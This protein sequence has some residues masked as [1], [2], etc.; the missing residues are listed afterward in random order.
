MSGLAYHAMHTA[1]AYTNAASV[2]FQLTTS[3]DTP[4]SIEQ[5]KLQ[6]GV[7][8]SAQA[9][10]RVQFG[11]YATGHAAGT[12]VTPT[13]TQRRNTLAADTVVRIASATLGT[14]FT[15]LREFQWNIAMPFEEQ[16]GWDDIKLEIPAATVFAIILPAASGTP[17]LSGGIDF[18]ER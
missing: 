8:S 3:A 17:T 10:V 13:A 5:V 2:I 9:I 1:T 15:A 16:F 7:T 18:V 6:S 14:T 12:T 4:I 11:T